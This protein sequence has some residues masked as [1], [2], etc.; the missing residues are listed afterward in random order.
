[1]WKARLVA[2]GFTEEFGNK[3]ECEAPTCFTERLKMVLM[4]I[5]TFGWNVNTLD[6]KTVYL[7]GKEITREIYVRPP[8]EAKC[9]RLWR[10]RKTVYGL[11]ALV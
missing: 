3:Y 5:K 7:Q 6:I 4:V 11:K 9:K 10:L 2:K 8:E 1:M